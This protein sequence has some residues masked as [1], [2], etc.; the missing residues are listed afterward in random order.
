MIADLAW[1]HKICPPPSPGFTPELMVNCTACGAPSGEQAPLRRGRCPSCYDVWLRRKPVGLGA[2]CLSCGERRRDVLR[3]FELARAWVVLCRNCAARAERLDPMPWFAEGLHM[4]L[5]RER[6][7]TD[8][9]GDV[10]SDDGYGGPE[11]R[12]DDR[13]ERPPAEPEPVTNVPEPVDDD[14][15]SAPLVITPLSDPIEA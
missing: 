6:R 12:D 7:Y 14:G 13:R 10:F 1:K 4:G 11:R 2:A 15:A 3:P 5:T 8:R 9:R